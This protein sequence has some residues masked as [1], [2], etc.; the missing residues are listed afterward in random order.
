MLKELVENH[1]DHKD[2]TNKFDWY[3][4]PIH[5]PD[6]YE[7]SRTGGTARLW[8]KTRSR[9]GMQCKVSI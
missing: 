7:F 4:L 9:V 8:R 6:G 1:K 3:F 5:N 2:L